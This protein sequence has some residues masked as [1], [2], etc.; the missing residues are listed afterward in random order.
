MKFNFINIIIENFNSII[1]FINE[2][3][4]YFFA[5]KKLNNLLLKREP[6]ISIILPTYNRSDMLKQRS[7]PTVLKQ[8]YRKFELIIISDGSTDDTKKIVKSFKDKRIKF[9][10][11]EREKKYKESVENHWFAGPVN[12]INKGLDLASG[13][14]IARIDDDDLWTK[15][16]LKSLLYHAKKKRLEFVSSA[17]IEYRYKKKILQNHKSFN[18]RIGGVQSWLYAG[19]LNFFKAN[20]DC[21]RKSWNKVND[22]DLQDRMYK[23]GIKMGY[24]DKVTVILKPRPGDKTIGLDAY[25]NKK[26]YYLKKYEFKE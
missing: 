8:S 11:I 15:D 23:V 12:A 20:K 13:D 10:E 21:W 19:Y 22:L 26:N 1:F 4:N 7:I 24:L 14:W 16:H 6:K 18:P 25:K 3:F 17:H 9:V 2:K 5:K